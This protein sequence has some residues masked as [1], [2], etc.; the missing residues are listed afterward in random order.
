MTRLTCR[1]LAALLLAAAPHVPLAAQGV[2]TGGIVHLAEERRMA[3]NWR[4]VLMIGAHPDD[5]N[6]ELLT[7]LAKEQGIETAYLSLTR[8]EGGQNLIGNELGV[9]LGVVRSEELL[10]ARSF[11]GGHQF[12]G[13]AFDFGFS[14]TMAEAFEFWPRDS[15]V[16]DAVRIIRRFRPQVVISVWSGTPA[17]GHGHHQ[18]AGNVALEAYRAAGDPNRFPE[19]MRE[20]GLA[21]YTVAKFYR[22]Y[23]FTPPPGP[24]LVLNGGA[25]DPVT[26]LSYHQIAVRSRD[27]HRSQNQGNL[28]EPG[29]SQV[30]L[31]LVEK[32]ATVTGPDDSVFAGVPREAPAANDLHRDAV[33]LIE[34]GVV[35]DATTS[36]DEVVPGQVLP[37]TLTVWNSGHDTV[38]ARVGTRLRA[39]FTAGSSDCPTEAV[40][41]APGALF[42]CIARVIVASPGQFT[43]PYYLQA[44]RIDAMYHW[45]GDPSLWGEPFAPPALLADFTIQTQS[46]VSVHAERE[47]QGRFRD[48]ILGE[49]RRRVAVVPRVAVELSPERLVWP[50]GTVRHS[51]RVALEHLSR[52]TTDVTVSLQ[53]P[54]GW[55]SGPAQPRHF[56]REGEHATV[57]FAVTAPAALAPGEYQISAFVVRGTDTLRTG[58]QRIRYP[59]ISDRNILTTPTTTVVVADVKF[60]ALSAI[61]YVRG[62]GDLVPEALINSGLPVKLL[63]GEAL[64]RGSLDGFKVIVIGAR[65]YEADESLRRA[66]P[67]LMRWL[68]AGGTLVVQIQQGIYFTGGYQPRPFTLG[69]PQDRVTDEHAKVTFVAPTNPLLNSP[70]RIT[71]ADF[72]GWIQERGLDFAHSWDAGWQPILEMHDA[73]DQPREGGLLITRVGRGT[74]IYTGLSFVRQLPA[75]VPGA[76][77]LF[78]NLLAAGQRPAAP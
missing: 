40:A 2:G 78:A 62:G 73:G 64:E 34:A 33:R 5:E 27:Q 28:E 36:D 41:V 9:G 37:V 67:R 49:V 54:P 72:D 30:R 16:K 12:F 56:V 8:G 3:G 18:A 61:G 13:R 71:A 10:A 22:S 68:N 4:R 74:A 59:H 69:S 70:N 45:I 14:K 6:T 38:R 17:D 58:I 75:A 48:Q 32:A 23:Y 50:R 35:L 39:A 43:A 42:R 25:V 19:L 20:E 44:P 55:K 29:P 26:G 51:F 66:H 65:A 76:W 1:S 11:D 63:T 60:P 24:L 53:L 21:P 47:V 46:G 77:R 31:G 15:L 7:I 57:D 52:D